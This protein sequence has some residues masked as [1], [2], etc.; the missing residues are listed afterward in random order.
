MAARPTVPADNARGTL[1][2]SARSVLRGDDCFWQCRNI[3]ELVSQ[4]FDPDRAGVGSSP[5]VGDM[6]S[7]GVRVPPE[8]TLSQSTRYL[9][10][11]AGV[12]IPDGRAMILHGIRQLATLRAVVR[13]EAD[14]CA[15]RVFEKEITS[16]L[17]Q[18]P[19]GNISWHLRLQ[20]N[21]FAQA[22]F[23]PKQRPGT[24]TNLNR[25][26]SALLYVPPLAPYK[27]PNNGI[28]PGAA[29]D[30]LGIW[31]DMRFPWD[32]T[33][34]KLNVL[35]TGPYNLVF[36]ASVR[37]P[38][39]PEEDPEPV[40]NPLCLRP[41]DQFLQCFPDAVYGRVAGAI[42]IETLPICPNVC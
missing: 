1:P 7:T 28:P 26:D 17:W 36:Y 42:T 19:N 12:Q 24:D 39:P 35:V 4:S 25:L 34:W 20:P 9:I 8:P 40:P 31:Y 2:A 38:A 16:P 14:P 18:F 13:S 41:E 22:I 27:P 29:E 30:Y 23:D 21:R 3:V 5:F 11:L 15:V 32:N 6:D 37:Q 33:D 10:R